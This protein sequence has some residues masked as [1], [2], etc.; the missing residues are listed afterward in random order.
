MGFFEVVVDAKGRVLI[1]KRVREELGIA[2]GRRLRV[3]VVDGKVVLEPVESVADRY[4]GAIK[5]KKWPADLD[6]FLEEAV[7]K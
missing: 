1:P 5:V 4:F 6:E 3:R 7:S 2:A